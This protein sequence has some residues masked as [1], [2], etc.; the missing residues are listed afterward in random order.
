MLEKLNIEYGGDMTFRYID[1]AAEEEYGDFREKMLLNNPIAGHLQMSIAV[2]EGQK[3][4]R[5]DVSDKKSL[6]DILKDQSFTEIM[7]LA[8]LKDLEKI[9]CRGKGFVLEEDNYVLHPEAVYFCPEGHAYLCYLPGYE[10][11]I[12]EQLCE[13]LGYLMDRVDVADRRSVYAI[14]S[15]Y[16]AAK[17]GNCTF[18]SLIN[19]L[20]KNAEPALAVRDVNPVGN[21]QERIA[22]DLEKNCG[23]KIRLRDKEKRILGYVSLGLCFLFVI[24]YFIL[25]S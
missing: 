13:L 5:Y 25:W 8:F 10:K 14:Y 7:L 24:V 20:E 1:F 16:A 19:R 23:R 12:Q 22:P 11:N 6:Q 9:F 15:T 21:E 4:Y 18:A 3:H 17:E 2:K